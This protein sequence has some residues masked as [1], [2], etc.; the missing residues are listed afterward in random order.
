MKRLLHTNTYLHLLVHTSGLRV[1]IPVVVE[2]FI[3]GR[4]LCNLPRDKS[5]DYDGVPYL[6][7]REHMQVQHADEH[8]IIETN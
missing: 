3:A 6:R 8:G 4:S 7:Q 5:L 2:R 1:V